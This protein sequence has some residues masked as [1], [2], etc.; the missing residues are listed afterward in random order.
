MNRLASSA[1]PVIRRDDLATTTS[2]D[3]LRRR[4]HMHERSAHTGRD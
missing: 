2:D 4:L 1:E 3:W